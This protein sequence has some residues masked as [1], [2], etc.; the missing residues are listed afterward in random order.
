MW[1]TFSLK[2]KPPIIDW[3]ISTG[4]KRLNQCSISQCRA[5]TSSCFQNFL[6]IRLMWLWSNLSGLIINICRFQ[7]Q[8]K[9]RRNLFCF[10]CKLDTLAQT[11]WEDWSER[12]QFFRV[13]ELAHDT[14]LCLWQKVESF[15]SVAQLFP[16]T[17][18]LLIRW[19]MFG[20]RPS[21]ALVFITFYNLNKGEVMKL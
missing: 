2:G 18:G 7:L 6:Y 10:Y 13:L 14:Y 3:N 21:P 1:H 17:G 19:Q 12:D 5:D 16:V 11:L 20:A 8:T 4:K 9:T 15:P